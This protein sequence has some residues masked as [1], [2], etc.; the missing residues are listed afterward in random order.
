MADSSLGARANDAEWQTLVA[1]ALKG[2]HF[3]TLRSTTYDGIVVDPLYARVKDA[4]P[5]A[6]RAAGQ[7]WAVMQRIDLPDPAA[8]NAQIL[9]DLNNGATGLTLLFPGSLS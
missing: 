2:A 7:A 3:D 9:D 1:E 8:A 6:G 5:I 4:S